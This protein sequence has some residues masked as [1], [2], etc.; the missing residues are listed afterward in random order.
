MG[1]IKINKYKFA[2]DFYET[3][4]IYPFYTNVFNKT[5][6]KNYFNNEINKTSDLANV[7]HFVNYINPYYDLILD[8]KR[9]HLNVIKL[10]QDKGFMAK[11][12]EFTSIDAYMNSK[13]SSKSRTK[14]RGYVRRLETCFNITYYTKR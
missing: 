8:K 7:V 10:H 2:F 4:R 12:N 6:G 1:I 13:M 14:M 9:T 3:R 11:L 5:N